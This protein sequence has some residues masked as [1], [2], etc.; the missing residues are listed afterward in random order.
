M[1]RNLSLILVIILMISLFAG[2]AGPPSNSDK[3]DTIKGEAQ[4][5]QNAGPTE[6][7][8]TSSETIPPATNI[9]EPELE[10][11]TEQVFRSSDFSEGLAAVVVGGKNGR[12]CTRNT[13]ASSSSAGT[14]SGAIFSPART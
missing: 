6:N 12:A 1:K 3:H 14:T 7:S 8:E 5:T 2:C 11:L 9:P 4:E 13:V 10:K